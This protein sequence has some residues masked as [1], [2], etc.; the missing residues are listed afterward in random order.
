[1]PV[2]ELGGGVDYHVGAEFKGTLVIRGQERVVGDVKDS[3]LIANRRNRR[4]V[5]QL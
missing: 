2:Q 1:V 4:E 5:G 3:G